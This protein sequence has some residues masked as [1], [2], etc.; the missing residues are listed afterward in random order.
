[1]TK[2]LRFLT[3][4]SVDDGKSTLIGRLLLDSK[5]ILTDQL[6]TLAKTSKKRGTDG[7]EL[8]LLT[9]GLIAEREQGITIDVAYRYFATP[10]RN[11]IIADCPGHE[12]Y[13]RNMVTG[14]ST[15]EAAIILVDATRG[16]RPQTRRH[17]YLVSLLR[18]PT[19]FVAVNKMDAV[20]YQQSVYEAIVKETHAYLAPLDIP[21]VRFLPVSALAGDNVVEASEQMPW[22]HEEPLLA[23]LE[24]VKAPP[25]LGTGEAV[26][27]FPVQYVLRH[28]ESA[29][30]GY[31]GRVESGCFT[32]GDA[33]T[34]LP[35]G[36]A[37]TIAGIDRLDGT[38]QTAQAG[39]SVALRLAEERD[40][41]RGDVI[42]LTAALPVV[43][44]SLTATLCWF[45]DMPLNPAQVYLLR[46]GTA[47]VKAKIVSIPHRVDVNTQALVPNPSTV[48]RND[49]VEATLQ[50]ATPI[51]CDPYTTNRQTGSFI[52]VDTFTNA[53]VAAGLIR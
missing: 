12:E 21:E 25:I 53:T 26:A 7:L 41:S 2:P 36:Q 37:A 33:V 43:T 32:V 28:H 34:L 39:E 31:L 1:M 17:G 51:A 30:R 19:V 14:A 22:W 40:V 45:D 9:D 6:A 38:Q 20:G 23:Q 10:K 29:Y 4:G 15:A 5:A 18:I 47:E 49:I 35:S 24:E 16:V 8:A 13:T 42:A 11:F 48:S 27:R 46:H 52:L 44:K 50:L 3:C